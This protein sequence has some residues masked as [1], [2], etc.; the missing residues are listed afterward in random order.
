MRELR[1]VLAAGCPANTDHDTKVRTTA[2][3]AIGGLCPHVCK[4]K[5]AWGNPIRD[6]FIGRD[7]HSNFPPNTASFSNRMS[8]LCRPASPSSSLTSCPT[9]R[10]TTSTAPRKVPA[11]LLWHSGFPYPELR[12]YPG[13]GV[14]IMWLMMSLTLT[15]SSQRGVSQSQ[16]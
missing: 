4:D 8:R 16:A 11:A 2:V 1:G 12:I 6:K 15:L 3:T 14:L 5:L 13:R 9:A 7:L 10:W